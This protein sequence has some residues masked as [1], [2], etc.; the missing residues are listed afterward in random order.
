MN[1]VEHNARTAALLN[2]SGPFRNFFSLSLN[3]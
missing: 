1:S 2:L 3:H